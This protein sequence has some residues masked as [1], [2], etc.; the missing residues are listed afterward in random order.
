M[1]GLNGKRAK[2]NLAEERGACSSGSGPQNMIYKR[3][4]DL[5][6]LVKFRLEQGEVISPEA[7]RA[8]NIIAA[9]I[10]VNWPK[11]LRSDGKPYLI[12]MRNGPNRLDTVDRFREWFWN[13][14]ARDIELALRHRREAGKQL[15]QDDAGRIAGLVSIEAYELGIGTMHPI[16]ETKE[17]RMARRLKRKMEND[18][19]RA[20]EKRWANGATPRHT[21]A[22]QGKPWEDNN[23][24]RRTWERREKRKR[25][26]KL[27]REI[28][29]KR[30]ALLD[31]NIGC[32]E[33]R[34]LVFAETPA[35]SSPEKQ[36]KSGQA[37]RAKGDLQAVPAPRSKAE[38]PRSGHPRDKSLNVRCFHG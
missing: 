32:D 23:E 16:D 26:E 4:T 17:E 14:D 1:T 27:A 24:S 20:A 6:K 11:R 25:E 30:R 18:R 35:K 33:L 10:L 21:K 3:K 31:K 9:D 15:S 19:I 37:G 34:H 36:K 28:D 2:T 12:D 8:F 13:A 22:S 38:G 5:I 7:W 29:A